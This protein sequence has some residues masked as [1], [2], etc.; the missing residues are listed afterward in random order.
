MHYHNLLNMPFKK[1]IFILGIISISCIISFWTFNQKIYDVYNTLGYI[2]NDYLIV[3]IPV[4]SPDTIS[5]MEYIKIDNQKYDLKIASISEIML[6]QNSLVNYQE[7]RFKV[8]KFYENQVMNVT[9][10]YNKEKVLEK[11]KKIIF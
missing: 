9:I 10:Y 5:Q 4:S 8:D 7:L 3:N 6:D 11:L 1:P 2:N